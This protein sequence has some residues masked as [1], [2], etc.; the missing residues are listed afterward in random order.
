MDGSVLSPLTMC[1]VFRFALYLYLLAMP[2]CDAGIHSRDRT[3]PNSAAELPCS[4]SPL[5]G[6]VYFDETSTF[7][8]VIFVSNEI[9]STKQDWNVT[10][11][12][13]RIAITLFDKRYNIILLTN[14]DLDVTNPHDTCNN[15]L[16]TFV[17]RISCFSGANFEKVDKDVTFHVRPVNEH[18]P[19]VGDLP[20]IQISEE[21][22][23]VP[24]FILRLSDF[25]TDRDCPKEHLVLNISEY[26]ATGMQVAHDAS[27]F[28]MINSTS[29]FLYQ[30]KV[31]DN[32]DI[33]SFIHCDQWKEGGFLNI[34]AN[35]GIH[36][37]SKSLRV[38]FVDIDD[39][40]PVFVMSGCTTICYVCPRTDLDAIVNYYGQDSINTYP[41]YITVLDP[42]TSTTNFTYDMEVYPKKYKDNIR[43]VN[44]SFHLLQPLANFTDFRELAEFK[45]T[46]V[47]QATGSNGQTGNCT[48]LIRVV[49]TP[50]TALKQ[51]TITKKF[52]TTPT[53]TS[54]TLF[55]KLQEMT[56]LPT[57][58]TY[59]PSNTTS[60][61]AIKKPQS[62]HATSDSTK[63]IVIIV[64]AVVVGLL[65]SACIIH[66]VCRIRNQK[67][68]SDDKVPSYEEVKR[69]ND[70]KE[71]EYA[72]IQN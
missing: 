41:P 69:N 22:Y 38:T 63:D 61:R 58:S 10:S 11:R 71:N 48:L 5:P 50:G 42:D 46:V 28:F 13:H 16:Q 27:Y 62:S 32:E 44:G 20:G 12:H 72:T 14:V 56:S 53:T 19:T 68:K 60:D 55:T 29:G 4:Y 30:S 18:P 1:C 52:E 17:Q 31:F 25:F 26:T 57:G 33:Y 67:T 3:P 45:I 49:D 59:T 65:I 66:T 21:T 47:L 15:L 6:H 36:K 9:T 8:S 7:G 70:T 51:T 37:T 35:D 43:F 34:T 2:L 23:S 64:L 40:P 54:N 39:H 24:N